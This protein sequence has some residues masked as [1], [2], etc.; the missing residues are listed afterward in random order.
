M[1]DSEIYFVTNVKNRAEA[2]EASFRVAGKLPELWHA[3]TGK[4]EPV[5]FRIGQGRT[6]IPIKLEPFGAVFVVFRQ[7]ALTESQ[8]V[9]E[10]PLE[11]LGAIKGPWRI[12][13]QPDRGA[14][15]SIPLTNWNPGARTAM[16]G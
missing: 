12:D 3:E 5:S 10:P 15:P 1:L 16:P 2:V 7:P 8:E 14:P 4:S 13:F 11:T 6:N 9:P